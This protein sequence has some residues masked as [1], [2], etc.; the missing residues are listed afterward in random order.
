MISNAMP[1]ISGTAL[2]LDCGAGIGR[3]TKS[4]LLPIFDDVDLLE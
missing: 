2:A 1:Y 4:I 3:V